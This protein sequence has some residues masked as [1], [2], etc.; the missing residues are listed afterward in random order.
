[1]SLHTE[2]Q[3]PVRPKVPNDL[4]G[5]NLI[6]KESRPATVKSS[7]PQLTILRIKRKRNEEPLEALLVQQEAERQNN[8][9]HQ[10]KIRKNTETNDKDG[11]VPVVPRLFR[12]AET[13]GEQSFKNINE[14]RKLK[15]RISRRIQ[16]GS[17]PMTPDVESR[18][19]QRV[20]KQQV[21]AR[22]ARYR[23]IQQNRRKKEQS[24]GPP[25]VESAS[26]KM[27][28]DLFQ[29]YDAVKEKDSNANIIL[30]NDTEDDTVMCNFISMVKE[31]LTVEERDEE[32][33]KFSQTP[34]DD[35]DGYVYDVYYRDDSAVKS[36]FPSH[37]IG[38]LIWADEELELMNDDTD[39]S[40]VGDSEDEDSN[41]MYISKIYS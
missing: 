38:A 36:A 40:D 39:D 33:K 6:R 23:V 11:E 17:R 15:E 29:L 27:S 13:V 24:A 2:V 41:G 32:A 9:G 30:E 3:S 7:E 8:R 35:D 4:E 18:K 25:Q 19:E 34:I 28:A 20:E 16:P 37:N 14:A 21:D 12:L 31:Y 5:A 10:R 22:T 26:D 1:M